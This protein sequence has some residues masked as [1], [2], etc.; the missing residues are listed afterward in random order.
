MTQQ[1]WTALFTGKAPTAPLPPAKRLSGAPRF[2]RLLAMVEFDKPTEAF[3]RRLGRAFDPPSLA[4][5]LEL[6]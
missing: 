3:Q 1:E 5:M 4:R 2:E 6:I